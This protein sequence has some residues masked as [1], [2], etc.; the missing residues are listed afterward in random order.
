M[1]GSN[2]S[3]PFVAVMVLFT[4]MCLAKSHKFYNP[5]FKWGK[6]RSHQVEIL[7]SKPKQGTSHLHTVPLCQEPGNFQYLIMP[8]VH[9]GLNN[10][11]HTPR[12]SSKA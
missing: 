5:T 10:I 2:S 4:Y 8:P 1:H 3:M 6:S 9:A 7:L 11:S 12:S